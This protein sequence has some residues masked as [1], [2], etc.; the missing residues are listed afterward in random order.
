MNMSWNSSKVPRRFLSQS[1][2]GE[3]W[4]YRTCSVSSLRLNMCHLKDSSHFLPQHC[5]FT[6][7]QHPSLNL[8]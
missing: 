3:S 6:T 8:M 1:R 4:T 5:I 7:R 2:C